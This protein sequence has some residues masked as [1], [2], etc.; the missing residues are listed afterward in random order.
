MTL[1]IVISCSPTTTSQRYITPAITVNPSFSLDEPLKSGWATPKSECENQAIWGVKSLSID[2]DYLAVSGSQGICLYAVDSWQPVKATLS[3]IQVKNVIPSPDGMLLVAVS[4][5]NAVIMLDARTGDHLYIIEV[6]TRDI[7]SVIFSKNGQSMHIP[8]TTVIADAKT[9]EQFEVL[10]DDFVG[11]VALSPD[12]KKAV[13][14]ERNTGVM[15]LWDL[16]T[17]LQIFEAASSSYQLFKGE[18]YYD[19]HDQIYGY[20]ITNPGDTLVYWWKWDV[21]NN[22]IEYRKL[23]QARSPGGRLTHSSDGSLLAVYYKEQG[24]F[25]FD[26]HTGE[27]LRQLTAENLSW[28]NTYRLL[29]SPDGNRLMTRG[30]SRIFLFDV[31]TGRHL[32]SFSS[33]DDYYLSQIDF[34]PDS[35]W[36]ILLSYNT[37]PDGFS[38][39]FVNDKQVEIKDITNGKSL[40]TLKANRYERL[41]MG[42]QAAIMADWGKSGV[43]SPNGQFYAVQHPESIGGSFHLLLNRKNGDVMAVPGRGPWATFLGWAADSRYAFYNSYDQYG[44]EEEIVIDTKRWDVD[45]RTGGCR[46]TMSGC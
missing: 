3:N 9:G 33:P 1:F 43:W 13:S 29:F 4:R 18:L 36:L 40:H 44:S 31:R 2:D 37:S 38:A 19:D 7:D 30:S 15:K 20:A 23:S 12:G 25:L 14:F 46:W 28:V 10:P 6:E 5:Y 22:S 42:S 8:G 24:I 21:G 11:S 16:T 41:T 45:R 26:L 35:S 27:M 39:Q 34:S 17:G 32:H